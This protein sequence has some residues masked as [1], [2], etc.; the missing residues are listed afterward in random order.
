VIP[1]WLPAVD[2][3]GNL[4]VVSCYFGALYN[5]SPDIEVYSPDGVIAGKPVRS[6]HTH[7]ASIYDMKVSRSGEIFISDGNGV[8]VFAKDAAGDDPPARYIEWQ[9]SSSIAVDGSDNLYVRNGGSIAVFGPTATGTATPAR[10]ISGP[11]V[12]FRSKYNY[13][14]GALAVDEKG[15]VY[16]LCIIDPAVDGLNSFGVLEFA[17]DAD[18]DAEPLRYVTT[19]QMT[20][21]Y[22]NSGI[23]VDAAGIIYV[24]ASLALNVAAVL[25]F[26]PDASGSVT[27]SSVI[28]S[29][30]F[31]EN[32]GGIAVH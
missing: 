27:P 23:A 21:A 12:R 14:Y 18:G 32:A 8:S 5:C 11:H 28:T 2:G 25:E 7:I 4:Y 16:D 10:L 19:P 1:G 31:R 17:A 30:A 20:D 13:D 3:A 24:S 26:P 22:E 29:S 15:R 6:L 9:S